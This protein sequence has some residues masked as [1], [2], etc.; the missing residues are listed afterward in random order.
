[1]ASGRRR[2]HAWTDWYCVFRLC[3]HLGP[4]LFE[5]AFGKITVTVRQGSKFTDLIFAE[6]QGARLASS[7]EL[8]QSVD[9][10]VKVLILQVPRNLKLWFQLPRPPSVPLEFF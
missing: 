3:G 5:A 9:M 10:W 8:V 2:G 6:K 7:R 4:L 1:M